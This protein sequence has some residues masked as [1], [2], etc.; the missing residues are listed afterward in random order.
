MKKSILFIL[1]LFIVHVCHSQDLP[2]LKKYKS[3]IGFNTNSIF[4]GIFN[5]NS[6]NGSAPF[7]LL[8]KRQ[9]NDHMANRFGLQLNIR[10]NSKPS[11]TSSGS[12]NQTIYYQYSSYY[13][14][15]SIGREI[16]KQITKMWIFYGGADF[17]VNFQSSANSNYSNDNILQ[18]QNTHN[19]YGVRFSPFLGIRLA[20]N[21]RLYLTTETMLQ[22]TFAKLKST[23]KSYQP[24][25]FDY[26]T[27]EQ[28]SNESNLYVTPATG[29]SVFYRF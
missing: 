24:T 29:I 18:Q 15:I 16:Q 6:S 14:S 1:S 17:A 20:I 9:K 12:T 27:I 28:K 7:D 22:A 19:R 3:D 8:Y 5:S 13:G 11:F 4:A 25:T 23:S 2:D 21:D 10:N 26:S